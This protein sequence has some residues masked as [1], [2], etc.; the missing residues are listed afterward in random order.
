VETVTRTGKDEAVH[1]LRKRKTVRPTA[2]RRAAQSPTGPAPVLPIQRQQVREILGSPRRQSGPAG[3][4]RIQRQSAAAICGGLSPAVTVP[5]LQQ[6]IIGMLSAYRGRAW[7]LGPFTS[8]GCRVNDT[9]L[10]VTGLATKFQQLARYEPGE[11]KVITQYEKYINT[12]G[13]SRRTL[14]HL[15]GQVNTGK[16]VGITQ[17]NVASLN[18]LMT[19]TGWKLLTTPKIIKIGNNFFDW[20]TT[21]HENV[22]IAWIRSGFLTPFRQELHHQKRQLLNS[23]YTSPGL[24]RSLRLATTDHDIVREV[25]KDRFARSSL[26]GILSSWYQTINNAVNYARDDQKAYCVSWTAMRRAMAF[27]GKSC[28]TAGRQVCTRQPNICRPKP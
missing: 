14:S 24:K 26:Q 22:H 7:R 9:G 2:I 28:P 12:A 25:A 1:A 4:A 5:P 23:A 3:G 6:R 20:A 21:L 17:L 18:D 15:Q 8:L 11:K 16:A 27:I 13:N 10:P 19:T